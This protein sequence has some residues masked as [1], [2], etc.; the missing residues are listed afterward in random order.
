MQKKT[1]RNGLQINSKLNN[2]IN[3]NLTSSSIILR[4]FSNNSKSLE[5]RK[6]F[7]I[8]RNKLSNFYHF[9]V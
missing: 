3:I 7:K 2:V 9:S 5:K 1:P 8:R 6:K 4:I